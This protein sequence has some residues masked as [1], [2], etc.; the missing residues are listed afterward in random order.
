[1]LTAHKLPSVVPTRTHGWH[2]PMERQVGWE[3][4]VIIYLPCANTLTCSNAMAELPAKAE[5]Q[6]NMYPRRISDQES[7][8]GWVQTL[9]FGL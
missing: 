1:M 5:G 6:I 3:S 4:R 9:R 7:K 8:F 2:F